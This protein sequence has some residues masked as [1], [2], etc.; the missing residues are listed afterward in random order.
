MVCTMIDR[1]P[2][3]F[4]EKDPLSE[5]NGKT[6]IPPFIDAIEK[7]ISTGHSCSRKRPAWRIHSW[8]VHSIKKGW[9]LGDPGSLVLYMKGLKTEFGNPSDLFSHIQVILTKR[10]FR[11]P[12]KGKMKMHIAGFLLNT[13]QIILLKW[14]LHYGKVNKWMGIRRAGFVQYFFYTQARKFAQ[15][16]LDLCKWTQ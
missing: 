13:E 8:M 6:L 1:L 7:C 11:C 12:T 5:V 3:G 14:T 15:P 10:C 4:S 2:S 16:Y 9:V